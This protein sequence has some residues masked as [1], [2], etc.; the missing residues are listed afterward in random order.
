[1]KPAD[2]KQDTQKPV[3]QNSQEYSALVNLSLVG[4]YNRAKYALAPCQQ[5]IRVMVDET[6]YIYTFVP[7]S[8]Q[9]SNPLKP[10]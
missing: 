10:K 1:M 5:K 2:S 8:S 7:D 3:T 6:N 4:N 9:L